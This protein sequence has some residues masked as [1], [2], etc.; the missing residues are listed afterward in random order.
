MHGHW[1][2]SSRQQEHAFLGSALHFIQLTWFNYILPTFAD[3]QVGS[4]LHMQPKP[5]DIVFSPHISSL[6]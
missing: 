5:S 4:V 1:F 2:I 3:A 6:F